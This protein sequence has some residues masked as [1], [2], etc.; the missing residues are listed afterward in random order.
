MRV[1]LAVPMQESTEATSEP[2]PAVIVMIHGPGLDR[3]IEAMVDA[4]A[5]HGFIAA[6][7]DL[8]HRQPADDG[9]DAMARIA[10]LRDREIVEDVTATIAHLRGRGDVHPGKLGILGFCM[11]GR[12]AYLLAGAQPDTFAAVG[13]FYGGNIMKAWPEADGGP[14]PFDRTDQ[15]A[16]PV[17]G[18]FGQ[19]DTN[20]SPSDVAQLGAALVSAGARHTFHSYAGA[21]HAFLNFTNAERHRP[22][23]AADAWARLLAFLDANLPAAVG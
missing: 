22:A 16:C 13:V 17:L 19:D 6:A 8:Y 5:L 20:P 4:L 9:A 12:N 23:Q 2:R 1:Y 11:G 21:G 10:R 15:I 3:F 14:S 7:P 18:L